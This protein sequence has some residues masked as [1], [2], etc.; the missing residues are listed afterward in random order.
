MPPCTAKVCIMFSKF[1][2]LI[3]H[4]YNICMVHE[5]EYAEM[6]HK[7]KKKLVNI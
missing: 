1:Y 2:I 4:G 6:F 7:A 5:L 3:M